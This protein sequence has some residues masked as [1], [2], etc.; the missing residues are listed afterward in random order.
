[1]NKV[2][3]TTLL[4]RIRAAVRA[5]QG[6]PA[7]SINLGI[8]VKRCDECCIKKATRQVKTFRANVGS[9]INIDEGLTPEHEGLTPEHERSL[10]RG[11]CEKIAWKMVDEG[12]LTFRAVP[13][14]QYN[15]TGR[16]SMQYIEMQVEV[17]VVMPDKEE[18]QPNE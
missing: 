1:M 17:D 12:A 7:K 5:F 13:H 16:K 4:D 8:D 10:L 2:K 14:T 11:C 6:K 15:M 3:K 18:V 9:F